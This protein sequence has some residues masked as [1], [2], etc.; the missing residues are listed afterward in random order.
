MH[1][2]TSNAPGVSR[3]RFRGN[4]PI[5]DRHPDSLVQ[6]RDTERLFAAVDS[7]RRRPAR[8]AGQ[9]PPP[10]PT[11]TNRFPA[12]PLPIRSIHSRRIGSS[13]AMDRTSRLGI[14]PLMRERRELLELAGIHAARPSRGHEGEGWR[15]G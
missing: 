14:P 11:S 12:I 6:P 13:C 7:E 10:Q 1:V 4:Q 3:E 5:V 9:M 8:R 2:T 15:W